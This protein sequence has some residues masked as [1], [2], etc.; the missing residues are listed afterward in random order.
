MWWHFV[1]LDHRVIL[2][3]G[4]TSLLSIDDR[5]NWSNVFSTNLGSTMLLS[6]L[7]PAKQQIKQYRHT[8][9]MSE[10]DI[11]TLIHTNKSHLL[12]LLIVHWMQRWVNILTDFYFRYW[13][14]LCLHT[15]RPTWQSFEWGQG[16]LPTTAGTKGHLCC[17][18]SG[19]ERNHVQ[20]REAHIRS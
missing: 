17:P 16:T 2:R 18:C 14:Q 3:L 12:H 1:S 11:L 4:C 7:W 8:F 6:C 13:W 19:D 9:D 5:I 10:S 20:C 15:E